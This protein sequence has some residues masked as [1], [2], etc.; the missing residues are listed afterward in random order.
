V[1]FSAG[2]RAVFAFG[3]AKSARGNIDEDDE[4]DLK[5][6]AKLTLGFT[7]AEI[8]KLV[9]VGTLIEVQCDDE[10]EQQD[11]SE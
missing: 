5:K 6:A 10:E 9:E 3:F 7:E 1:F 11:V 4:A 8:D 2:T